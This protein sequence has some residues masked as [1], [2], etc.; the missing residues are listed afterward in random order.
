[1]ADRLRPAFAA[2]NRRNRPEK[3]PD[4][5]L[6]KLGNLGDFGPKSPDFKTALGNRR[7]EADSEG[8]KVQTKF[9]TVRRW[10]GPESNRRHHDFQSCALPTELPRLRPNRIGGAG[11]AEAGGGKAGSEWR[12]RPERGVGGQPRCS[13]SVRLAPYAN[14]AGADRSHRGGGDARLGRLAGRFRAAPVLAREQRAAHG[15]APRDRARRQRA[16]A[17]GPWDG[18]RPAALAGEGAA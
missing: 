17:R 8:R 3:S 4:F 11:E 1:M 18:P 12:Q 9:Q 5:R 10:R 2:R 6:Q 13:R 7:S 14:R 15:G 16:I